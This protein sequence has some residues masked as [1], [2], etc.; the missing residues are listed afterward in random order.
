MVV[1]KYSDTTLPLIIDDFINYAKGSS[2]HRF[3]F[4]ITPAIAAFLQKRIP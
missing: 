1:E 3:T 2:G 4:F